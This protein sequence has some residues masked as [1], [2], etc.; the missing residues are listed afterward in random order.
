MDNRPPKE[1][2]HNA[3]LYIKNFDTTETIIKLKREAIGSITRSS[4]G[5][6]STKH[7]LTL[8]MGAKYS[9]FNNEKFKNAD[10]L[11]L[12]WGNFQTNI[13]NVQ[14]ANNNSTIVFHAQHP[15]TTHR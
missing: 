7:T 1:A 15:M 3:D 4:N 14:F 9:V 6:P 10:R 13:D 8:A 11:I 12:I 5:V 2:I